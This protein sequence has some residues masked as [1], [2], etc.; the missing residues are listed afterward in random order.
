MRASP[1]SSGSNSSL[2][3]AASPPRSDS[4]IALAIFAAALAARLVFLFT[5]P[6]CSWPHSTYYEGDAIMW[7]E[8]AAALDSHQVFEFDLPIHPPGV[9]Y[10]IAWLYRGVHETGFAGMKILWCVMSAGACSLTFLACARPLGRRV[11]VFAALLLTFSF[12][13]YLLATSLNSETPYV[14]LLATI[15][16]LTQRVINLPGRRNVA[17]LGAL[18]GL[19]L[20]LRPEHPILML[21][22]GAWMLVPRRTTTAVDTLVPLR[23]RFASVAAMGVIAIVTC[24]PWTVHAI[25]ATHRFNNL[26]ATANNYNLAPIEWTPSARAALQAMPAFARN[27]LY[28][29]FNHITQTAGRPSVSGDDV[30]QYLIQSFNWI[31]QPLPEKVLVSSQGAFSFALANHPD[32]DGGFSRA[33]IAHPMRGNN[34]TFAFSFPPHNRVFVDGWRVGWGYIKDDPRTW[35]RNVG[36]KFQRFADGVTCGFGAANLPLDRSGVRE[37]VDM[38]V[39]DSSLVRWWQPIILI[40]I[41]T[42]V[43]LAFVRRIPVSLW[44]LIILYKLLITV[45]FYGYARQGAS[46]APAFYVFI[47]IALDTMLVPFGRRAPKLMRRQ[48][49]TAIV[50]C[51][52][53]LAGDIAFSR[54]GVPAQIISKTI[55]RPEL[56]S[57]AFQAFNRI[58]IRCAPRGVVR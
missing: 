11:G 38:F 18:H 40:L 26:Q 58:E 3:T 55:A 1:V 56:G 21:L 24:L 7:V 12:N 50:F 53:M 51:L 14:L 52:L 10:P 28:A 6:D 2:A 35:L 39:S 34:P 19:S 54:R 47:A 13:Q 32:S 46:I 29:V 41:A 49:A 48:S 4:A 8:W 27:D 16:L 43:V 22:L 31:P 17:A 15:V 44:L 5:S 36:R 9:A 37:P 42:G 30:H 25:V 33:A 45:A 23:V 20:L 57:G